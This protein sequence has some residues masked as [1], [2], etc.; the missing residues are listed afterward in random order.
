MCFRLGFILYCLVGTG[1]QTHQG[2]MWTSE[3]GSTQ[4]FPVWCLDTTGRRQK[5][6]TTIYIHG[7]ARDVKGENEKQNKQTKNLLVLLTSKA[8]LSS[9]TLGGGSLCTQIKK[10]ALISL[11]LMI[12]VSGLSPI[13]TLPKPDTLIHHCDPIK[14]PSFPRI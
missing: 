11:A 8:D 2:K 3:L 12:W 7:N 4:A 5:T 13:N 10:L 14:Q 9:P 6:G 1:A